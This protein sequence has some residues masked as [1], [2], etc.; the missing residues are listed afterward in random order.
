[1]LPQISLQRVP[2]A[3][4]V[5]NF[6]ARSANGQQPAQGFDL[7]DRGLKLLNQSFTF[8]FGLFARGDVARNEG[9][10][11]QFPLFITHGRDDHVRPK[12]RPSLAQQQS[13]FFQS[14]LDYG[15]RQRAFRQ[16][17]RDG[18]GREETGEM[19]PDDLAR[20]I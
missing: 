20:L 9:K 3:P 12:P 19:A 7:A 6:F 5:T 10:A 17:T 15:L 14:T 13:F 8:R 2:E 1:M 4:V 11:P 16:T 18:F